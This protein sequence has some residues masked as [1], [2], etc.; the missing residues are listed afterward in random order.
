MENDTCVELKTGDAAV[1]HVKQQSV[2]AAPYRYSKV[3]KTIAVYAF[4]TYSLYS[5]LLFFSCS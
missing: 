4:V 1:D 2:P 3:N 5:G